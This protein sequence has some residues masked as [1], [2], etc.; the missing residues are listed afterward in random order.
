M[1]FCCE[2]NLVSRQLQNVAFKIPY[3]YNKIIF[4]Q[5]KTLKTVNKIDGRKGQV[6]HLGPFKW[7]SRYG[8][9][10]HET[11]LGRNGVF[12]WSRQAETYL[13]RVRRE[14]RLSGM[15]CLYGRKHYRDEA[16]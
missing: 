5:F 15:A 1:Y 4:E 16:I 10:R 8:T 11:P 6:Q 2:H 14:T 12:I 9:F 7:S 13:S 3:I